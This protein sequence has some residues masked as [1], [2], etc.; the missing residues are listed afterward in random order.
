M[1]TSLS[2]LHSFLLNEK[3]MDWFLRE[4]DTDYPTD[5]DKE[6]IEH[7]IERYRKQPPEQMGGVKETI[8]N[9]LQFFLTPDITEVFCVKKSTFAFHEINRGKIICV[10]MP[11]KYQAERRYINTFLKMLFYTHALRRFD[12]AKA[13]RAN[14]NLLILW[15]D[16]AQRFVTASDEGM[17]DYNCVDVMREARATL[18]AVR[19]RQRRS[20]R[21][22]A[23]K[24][25]RC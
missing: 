21:P 13:D 9:Y 6:L 4:L 1:E 8:G 24:K 5:R 2:N 25:P 17:S 22:W 20:F 15:A 10:A 16:E 11:Q 3:T 23:R 19:S 12:R 7:F 18:V 14:D